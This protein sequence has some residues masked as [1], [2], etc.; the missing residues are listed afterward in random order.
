[1][2][3]PDLTIHR[4]VGPRSCQVDA[5][6]SNGEYRVILLGDQVLTL[7]GTDGSGLRFGTIMEVYTW[8]EEQLEAWTQLPAIARF[9]RA[10]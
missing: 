6:K 5:K 9:A 8:A 7:D 4:Y 1:M 3:Q 2:Y 10:A